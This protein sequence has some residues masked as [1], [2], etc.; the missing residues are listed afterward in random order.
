MTHAIDDDNEKTKVS[1]FLLHNN[2]D[3]EVKSDEKP[4]SKK[5][6]RHRYYLTFAVAG[7]FLIFV[8]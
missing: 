2:T 3:D 5:F 1:E 7:G 8:S 6:K 4:P